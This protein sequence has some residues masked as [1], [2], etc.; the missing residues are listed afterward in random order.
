MNLEVSGTL[1]VCPILFNLLQRASFGFGN[2][3]KRE[4]KAENSD[5]AENPESVGLTNMFKQNREG[6]RNQEVEAKVGH[7]ADAH[8]QTSDL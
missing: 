7:G 2:I 3:E 4:P 8:C 5:K 1:F 6:E